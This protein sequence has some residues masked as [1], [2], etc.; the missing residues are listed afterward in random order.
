VNED[1]DYMK[2]IQYYKKNYPSVY[3]L[4]FL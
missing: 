2:Q 1:S 3:D 4:Q